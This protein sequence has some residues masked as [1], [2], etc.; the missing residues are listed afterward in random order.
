MSNSSFSFNKETALEN[1]SKGFNSFFERKGLRTQDI[2][3]ELDVTDSAVSSWKYGR[4][5]PDFPKFLRLVELGLSPF[6]IMDESLEKI[7]RT[8][9]DEFRLSGIE[10][11]LKSIDELHIDVNAEYL[12]QLNEERIRLSEKLK[13]AKV[14]QSAQFK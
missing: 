1:F 3:K 14:I 9:D 6:E 12:A 8:N 5:F 11:Q 2:A 7:A 4:A 13:Q 10:K